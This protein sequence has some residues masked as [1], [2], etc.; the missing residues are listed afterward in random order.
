MIISQPRIRTQSR[1]QS[2]GSEK[3]GGA[4]ENFILNFQI[5]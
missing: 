3:Q 1:S 2:F 5:I 4:M